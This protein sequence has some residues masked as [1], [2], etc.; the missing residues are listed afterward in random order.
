MVV[1]LCRGIGFMSIILTSYEPYGKGW[2]G[3][4]RHYRYR[5]DANHKHTLLYPKG[6]G[7]D[8]YI[9]DLAIPSMTITRV[10]VAWV[11]NLSMPYS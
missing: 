2:L 3:T 4:S 6:G 1:S 5:A 9:Y 8:A 7:T 11:F 10:R